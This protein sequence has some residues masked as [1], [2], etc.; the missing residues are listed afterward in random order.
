MPG[1]ARELGGGGAP[2][3]AGAFDDEHDAWRGV[4]AGR[5][6]ELVV[7]AAGL[8]RGGGETAGRLELAGDGAA[9]DAR[10]DDEGEEDDERAARARGREASKS[11]EHAVIVDRGRHAHIGPGESLAL[12]R[13][14]PRE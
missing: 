6:R 11:F 2:F 9:H 12:P 13:I 5:L 4:L 8:R 7:G 1:T 3:G 14:L 10:E